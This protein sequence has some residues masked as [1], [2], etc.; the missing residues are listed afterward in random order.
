VSYWRTPREFPEANN[1]FEIL[2]AKPAV[3]FRIRQDDP[4]LTLLWRRTFG[5]VWGVSH[6]AERLGSSILMTT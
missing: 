5:R 2:G 1:L 6:N 3:G 4:K